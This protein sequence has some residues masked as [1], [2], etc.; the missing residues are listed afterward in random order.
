MKNDKQFKKN[1]SMACGRPQV[2]SRNSG[3]E[4]YLVDQDRV[5]KANSYLGAGHAAIEDKPVS[6]SLCDMERFRR[7]VP[8][9]IVPPRTTSEKAMARIWVDILKIKEVSVHDNFFVYGRDSSLAMEFVERVR[10]T[11]AVNLSVRALFDE[12]TLAGMTAAILK[13]QHKQ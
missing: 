9:D 7:E 4:K 5:P 1:N 2:Q 6:S 3:S 11:F 10:K 12:P 13:Y 8:G